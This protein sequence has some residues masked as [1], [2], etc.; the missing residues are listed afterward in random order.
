MSI[1]FFVA[2]SVQ[3]VIICFLLANILEELQELNNKGKR[4]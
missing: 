2:I 1:A 4:E 3:L